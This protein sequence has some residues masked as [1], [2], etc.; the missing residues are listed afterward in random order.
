MTKHLITR[1]LG[2]SLALS[3]LAGCGQSALLSAALGAATGDQLALQSK[4]DRG[5]RGGQMGDRDGG[6]MAMFATLSL[7]DDQKAQLQAIAE[8]YKPQAPADRQKPEGPGAKLQTILTT[9][10]LDVDALK[11]A[12]AEKPPAPKA[13]RQDNRLAQLVEVRAVLTEEQRAKLVEQLKAQPTPAE[14]SDRPAPPAD[15]KRPDSAQFEAK[16]GLNDEQKAAFKAFQDKL[17][18]NRPAEPAKKPDFAAHRAAE[19][20]FWETGDTTG[21]T[22]DKPVIIEP[23]A[24][25]VDEFVAFVTSLSADQRKQVFA[26]GAFGLG[27]GARVRIHHEGPGGF[28]VHIRR[29]GPGGFDGPNDEPPAP[30]EQ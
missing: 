19:I 27:M 2:L 6:P 1:A 21:L 5:P 10:T 15:A 22:S 26:H 18:A 9:D 4:G 28:G 29:E 11:A 12:L 14:P 13:D 24:F 8:K 30:P 3:T 23:P 20:T 25:P 16:L 7:T 17:E